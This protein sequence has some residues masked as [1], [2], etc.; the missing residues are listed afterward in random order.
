MHDLYYSI[1]PLE[2]FSIN[3]TMFPLAREMTELESDDDRYDI[4]GCGAA[5]QPTLDLSDQL[6]GCSIGCT[7]AIRLCGFK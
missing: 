2:A 7:C 6:R 1:L 5:G 3:A 4:V